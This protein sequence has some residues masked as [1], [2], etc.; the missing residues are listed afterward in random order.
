MRARTWLIGTTFLAF[1][2][3]AHAAFTHDPL[4]DRT[5]MVG[6]AFFEMLL[7]V[8]GLRLVW[9]PLLRKSS[10]EGSTFRPWGCLVWLAL[11]LAAAVAVVDSLPS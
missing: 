2:G 7:Y 11:A 5:V 3:A 1:G 4:P 9:A 6:F 8:A 10:A